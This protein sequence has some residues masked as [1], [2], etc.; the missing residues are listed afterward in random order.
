VVAPGFIETDMTAAMTPEAEG[1]L[2]ADSAGAPRDSR[3]HRGHGGLLASE[4][5]GYITGQVFVVDGG[6]VM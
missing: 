4:H 6:L 5:A 1:T 2:S 3:G